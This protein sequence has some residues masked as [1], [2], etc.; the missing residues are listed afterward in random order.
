MQ[1][2]TESQ[3]DLV[4]DGSHERLFITDRTGGSVLVTD[5]TGQTL[6][7]LTDMEGASSIVLSPDSRT[8]YVALRDANAIAAIDT[9]TLTE[10]AR[11]AT[12]EGTAPTTLAVAGGKVWFGFGGIGT[13]HLG[14][15]DVS[16]AD[17][18]VRLDHDGSWSRA[19][20]LASSPGNPDVLVAG[21]D[22]LTFPDLTVYDV[23][24]DTPQVR[25]RK[26]SPGE[27]GSHYLTDLA[28]TPSGDEIVTASGNP[29]ALQVFSTDDL[30]QTSSHPVTSS[31]RAVGVGA[32]GALAA[33]FFESWSQDVFTF[34]P[35]YSAPLAKF[36]VADQPSGV[37]IGGVAWG[38]GADHPM[39]FALTG[40][41][42]HILEDAANARTAVSLT[43]PTTAKKN[44]ELT[45]TGALTPSGTFDPDASVLVFRY[46]A[47]HPDGLDLGSV[48]VAADSTFAFTDSV[49]QPGQVEYRVWYNADAWHH[50][51]MD[52]ATVEITN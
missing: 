29:H 33:G 14:S 7:Q 11:Y 24:S 44:K 4:A 41:G 36:E 38:D 13:S 8:V 15:V 2:P 50:A 6:A 26:D 12:G 39:L 25:V 52:S 19:P 5:Y 18:V 48:P 22:S 28:M 34:R 16:S 9:E 20:L 49:R 3:T 40:D 42:L 45:V 21:E 10:T 30:S 51:G 31:P 27:P 1:L 35:G 46:D 17:P 43:A 23:S 37:R 32:D 47:T